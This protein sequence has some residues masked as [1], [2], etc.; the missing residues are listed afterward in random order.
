MF[1]SLNVN[2]VLET[3]DQDKITNFKIDFFCH[4]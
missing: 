3:R 2:T 4:C 1:G